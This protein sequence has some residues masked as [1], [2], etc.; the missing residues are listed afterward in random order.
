MAEKRNSSRISETVFSPQSTIRYLTRNGLVN[1]SIS[2]ISSDIVGM[3]AYGLACLPNIWIP[4]FIVIKGSDIEYFLEN[5]QELKKIF[6]KIDWL[7]ENV[8]LY[9]RSSAINETIEERGS[10][11]SFITSSDEITDALVLAD[12]YSKTIS[13]EINWILQKKIINRSKGHLSNERRVGTD[14]RDF[15]LEIEE[16]NFSNI[17][18]KA[19]RPWRDGKLAQPQKLLCNKHL[20]IDKAIKPVMLWSVEKK[21]RLHFE[22]VWDG[23]Q[24]WIVQSDICPQVSGNTPENLIKPL[25][26]EADLDISELKIFRKAEAGDFNSYK[27]LKNA[28]IYESI[29]KFEMTDFYILDKKE[30][31]EKLINNDISRELESDLSLLLRQGPLVVRTD[32]YN[33]YN[34]MLPRS[35]ELRSIEKIIEWFSTKLKNDIPNIIDSLSEYIFICHIFIPAIASAWSFAEPNKRRV[36]IEALWG[37][38]EGMYWFPHDVYEVDTPYLDLKKAEENINKFSVSSRIRYKEK[39]IAPNERGEW[40]TYNSNEECDWKDTISNKNIC[41]QIALNSRKIADYINKPVNIMWFIEAYQKGKTLKFIPWYHHPFELNKSKIKNA[42]KFKQ[43]D[44]HVY[45]I[46]TLLDWEKLKTSSDS[47]KIDRIIILPK[48]ESII[49]NDIFIKELTD[50]LNKT[51]IVVE[52]H[53]GILSHAFYVLQKA[54][55]KVEV[56]DLFG[57]KEESLVFKKI[58][59]DKIPQNI[60]YKGEYVYQKKVINDLLTNS[61]KVKLVEEALEVFD[62]T[63]TTEIVEEIADVLEVIEALTKSLDISMDEIIQVKEEKKKDKGGFDEGIVLLKTSSLGSLT[64]NEHEIETEVDLFEDKTSLTLAT[65]EDLKLE[66][67]LHQDEVNL[68]NTNTKFLQVDF[69]LNLEEEVMRATSIQL[70]V[71]DKDILLPIKAKWIISRNGAN[72]R[73]R[74][75]LQPTKIQGEQLDLGL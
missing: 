73:V 66:I 63:S 65:K 2:Q 36:R 10:Y 58:V 39:F 17:K 21:L 24:I 13:T 47:R 9:L 32:K 30:E 53:G 28:Q 67:G 6:K 8:E 16:T 54:G 49:R 38:P 56:S 5:I 43:P 50:Y 57:K 71:P 60:E 35:D 23:S 18:N 41:K 22:W 29:L 45:Y 7:D 52:L 72:V 27:K 75:E 62:A 74:I 42:P 3:K 14:L 59:R 64:T 51:S 15:V 48:E 46:H 31:I 44:Q 26:Y 33:S 69:P 25:P 19:V 34:H 70:K 61:L 20:S 11:E 1:L 12:K 37:I 68:L 4:E 55:C 40:I